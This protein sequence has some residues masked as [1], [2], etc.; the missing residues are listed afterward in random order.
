MLTTS[1]AQ[2]W[3]ALSMRK[4]RT[5]F[6]ASLGSSLEM[7]DF[8]VYG[9]FA[10]EIASQ[11]FP[12]IDPIVALISSF[13]VFAVGYVSRPLGAIVLSSFG[14][15]HG[16]KHVFLVSILAMSGSTIGI[17]VLPGYAS[18]G[19]LAPALLI[20]LRLVQGFFLA[21]E[22]P[23]AITYVVEEIPQKAGFVS[24]LVLFFLN[25]GIFIATMT[26]FVIQSSL[27]AA[28]VHSYGWR[29]AFC[30][31]GL[32]GL[33][34]YFLRRSLEET[35]EF[36]RMRT[37][38]SRK[39]FR[40]LISRHGRAVLIGV[41]IS[42]VVNASNIML[43]VF[44]P[45]F[46]TNTLHHDPRVVSAC[47]NVG[48]ACLSISI[49]FSGWLCDHVPRRIVHRIGALLMIGGSYPLY[50]AL[51][52]GTIDLWTAVIAM[53]MVGGLVAGAYACILADLFPT[54]VRF[55]GIALSLNLSTVIFTGLTPV[56][57]TFFIKASKHSAMPGL[58]L[59]VV[60]LFAF[61][62]GLVLK[63]RGGKLRQV[64]A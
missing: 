12:A 19:V 30:L 48:I 51:V 27:S 64:D 5:V 32:L 56:A 6:L 54:E 17:G 9:V 18:I 35:Q 62:V 3:A 61:S 10:K 33:L 58:Y 25:S 36:A 26:N 53:G 42:S 43:F 46:A 37:H 21:G 57:I 8:I 23:C 13:G 52:S 34:S 47:Q 38:V 29:I 63:R 40:D 24:G 39:P 59:A 2:Q 44:F 31:G 16:R 4:W 55:S 60:A 1:T 20:L 50:L 41:G 15:R 45:N 11:F 28:D 14:D 49:L 7:Y 22:L